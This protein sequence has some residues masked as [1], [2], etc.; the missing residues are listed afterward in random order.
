MREE[1]R[2]MWKMSFCVVVLCA[3]FVMC[4]RGYFCVGFFYLLSISD[5][6]FS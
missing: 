3:K 4:V 2:G 1:G 6:D 5:N